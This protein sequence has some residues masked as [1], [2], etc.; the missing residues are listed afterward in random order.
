MSKE[1]FDK[2]DTSDVPPKECE[3]SGMVATDSDRRPGHIDYT[4][5]TATCPMCKKTGIGVCRVF[6]SSTGKI[7]NA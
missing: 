5:H 7:G 4:N 3:G 1:L 2:H 6:A